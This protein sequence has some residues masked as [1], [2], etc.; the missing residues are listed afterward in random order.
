MR[1]L[2]GFHVAALGKA[3]AIAAVTAGCICMAEGA[4]IHA[5]A[6][7]AQALI[8]AAWHRELAGSHRIQPWPWADTRPAARLT[9][10]EGADARVL[11]VLEGASGRNL[12]FGPA[13]DPSSVSPG[14]V[15]NSVIEGHR[16]TH[17]AVLR[18]I[19]VGDLMHVETVANRD[20]RFR[21][22][23]IQVVDSRRVRIALHADR[24]RL[25]LVTCYPFDAV[26][27]GGPMRLVVTA[28]LATDVTDASDV[29]SPLV[30]DRER[31]HPLGPS[32]D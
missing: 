16:D 18:D 22:T 29:G 2:D 1:Y 8:V 5:K 3:A 12:A 26:V 10:G 6:S 31:E 11:M 19:R 14:E 23:N 17:F 27:P 30:G 9:F 13:H 32:L 21:V 20:S 25:T 28:D 24:P 15:G 7:F 4:W